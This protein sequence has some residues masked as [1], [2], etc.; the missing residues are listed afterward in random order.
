MR[1]WP[2]SPPCRT[3][4]PATRATRANIRSTAKGG[5]LTAEV[6]G[7]PPHGRTIAVSNYD[8]K[9]A[10]SSSPQLF[11]C[12]NK[13]PATASHANYFAGASKSVPRNSY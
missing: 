1:S 4:T 3:D 8:L 6:L 10:V 2:F 7:A 11:S 12:C 13:R 5:C 9:P